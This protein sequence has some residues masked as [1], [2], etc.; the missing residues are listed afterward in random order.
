MHISQAPP[1]PHLPQD[2][3]YGPDYTLAG[4]EDHVN[5]DTQYVDVAA[6]SL[7]AM[8]DPNL[9]ADT[10]GGIRTEHHPPDQSGYAENHPDSFANTTADGQFLKNDDSLQDE[11][12]NETIMKALQNT[13]EQ[14]KSM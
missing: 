4:I 11:N 8:I 12:I 10:Q 14:V 9:E 1:L 7:K 2:S 6:S 3:S 5:V 13:Q